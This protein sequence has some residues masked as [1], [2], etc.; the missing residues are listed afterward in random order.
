[1]KQALRFSAFLLILFIP[2]CS[3]KRCEHALSIKSSEISLEA[4]SYALKS[5]ISSRL[6]A[7]ENEEI[8]TK[9]KRV[10]VIAQTCAYPVNQ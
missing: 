3:S 10:P 7:L 4:K 9:P 1:M 2:F 6:A 5:A 8:K